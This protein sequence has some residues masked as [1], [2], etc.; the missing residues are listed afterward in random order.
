MADMQYK[1][2]AYLSFLVWAGA[3]GLN[4]SHLTSNLPVESFSVEGSTTNST[5]LSS[6]TWTN[7]KAQLE[8]SATQKNISL[9][10]RLTKNH[11]DMKAALDLSDF[12]YDKIQFQMSL[13]IQVKSGVP[14]IPKTRWFNHY[15][16]Q[17]RD[18]LV[19]VPPS[20]SSGRFVVK[21]SFP[22]AYAADGFLGFELGR[23]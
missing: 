3:A 16:L 20:F 15:S 14:G 1:Y 9:C 12:F 11:Q 6:N 4:H 17:V 21:I 22:F 18:A 23:H 7:I 2:E 13:Y 19:Q 8:Q 5:N 10:L